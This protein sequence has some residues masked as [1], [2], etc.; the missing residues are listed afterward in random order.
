MEQTGVGGAHKGGWRP[1]AS[2]LADDPRVAGLRM[3]PGADGAA[4]VV[5]AD[6]VVDASDHGSR[7]PIWL[8]QPGTPPGPLGRDVSNFLRLGHGRAEKAIHQ[9]ELGLHWRT[10][11]RDAQS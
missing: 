7:T 11:G 9:P 2:A 3:L 1:S 8:S 4:Q 6:L 5:D 10:D